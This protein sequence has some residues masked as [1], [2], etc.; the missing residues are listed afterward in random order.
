MHGL[1][2]G[3]R[4]SLLEASQFVQTIENQ[5]GLKIVVLEESGFANGWLSKDELLKISDRL[6][7]TE[8][9]RYLADLLLESGY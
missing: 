5:Q 3:T 6:R 7:H 9:G 1:D 2:T 8:Y 4:H